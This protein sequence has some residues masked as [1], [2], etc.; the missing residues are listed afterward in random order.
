MTHN[1]YAPPSAPVTDSIAPAPI[2]KPWQ[3]TYAVYLFWASFAL[4]IL[5]YV[6]APDWTGIEETDDFALQVVIIIFLA[7]MVAFAALL[8]VCIGWGHRW[9]RIVYSAFVVW[10]CID[11][12]QMVGESFAR[13]W[14]EG[15]VYLLSF[16][17]DLAGVVLMFTPPANAWFRALAQWRRST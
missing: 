6:L 3:V 16:V 15:A 13:F 1:P 14:L 2:V 5:T 9:A 4:A 11:A 17:T 12:Y 8:I 10:S 7:A